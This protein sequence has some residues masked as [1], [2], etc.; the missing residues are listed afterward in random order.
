[1]RG[2]LSGIIWGVVASVVGLAALSLLSDVAPAPEVTSS[3]PANVAETPTA[4]DVGTVV[5]EKVDPD[6]AETAPVTPAD[7]AAD[8]DTLAE[9]EQGGTAP[10]DRPEVSAAAPQGSPATPTPDSAEVA[11][12]PETPVGTSS[13]SS[14]P[15]APADKPSLPDAD[16]APDQPAVSVD[17]GAPPATPDEA[18]SDAAPATPAPDETAPQTATGVPSVAEPSAEPAPV[19]ATQPAAA[20]AAEPPAQDTETA[21]AEP[22]VTDAEDAGPDVTDENQITSAPEAAEATP[23]PEVQDAAVED[24][25]TERPAP[26]FA[27]APPEITAPDTTETP[28]IIPGA[29]DTAPERDAQTAALPQAGDAS[30]NLRPTIGKRVVPLT[31]R[32][33]QPTPTAEGTEAPARDMADDDRPPIE[34]F[35]AEFANPDGKPLMAIV[36]I[37]DEKSIG[38]EALKDFP[39]PLTFAVDPT[40]PGAA[41]KMARHRA[42]GFE[43][44]VMVDLPRAA[45]PQDAEVALSA[46]F[47]AV[48]EALAVME[49]TG[50]GIQGNRGLS[51]QVTA[52]AGST[53]RGMITLGN[54]LNTVQKLAVRDGVP[55]ASVFR[56]FDGAG[57]TP[58]VMRRFL[59]QAAFRAGQEGGVVMLGRV[60]PDTISALLLWGL[61]DRASRVALAPVSAVLKASVAN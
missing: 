46:S 5:A 57:Q 31:E 2:F 18:G 1:M 56:D 52:F 35:A 4:E 41:E 42:A 29:D 23:T 16:S 38:V 11:A 24:Q 55:A 51:G 3:G 39:Y 9:M 43:V 6:L 58:T 37:D 19:I 13:A 25:G 53:G 54:G 30:A 60:R 44:V 47:D 15:Q 33:T 36:L 28:V 40:A 8:Q 26:E 34:K 20:P 27:E 17:A 21:I 14:A 10:A 50:S 61:Q 49:G 12:G 7:A 48:P 22:E 45:T 59:D 32:N